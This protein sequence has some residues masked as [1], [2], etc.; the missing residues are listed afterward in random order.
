MA[1]GYNPPMKRF[2]ILFCVL[3]ACGKTPE[4]TAIKKLDMLEA[5]RREAIADLHR[6]QAECQALMIEAPDIP[7]M[8]RVCWETHAAVRKMTAGLLSDIDKRIAEIK[9]GR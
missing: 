9:A 4:E 5:S 3:A 2:A 7:E 6:N 1:F 8:H